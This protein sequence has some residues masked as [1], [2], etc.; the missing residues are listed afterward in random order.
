MEITFNLSHCFEGVSDSKTEAAVINSLLRCLVNINLAY[1]RGHAVPPLYRAGVVYGRT[2][3][4][5]PI[6]T[7][8]ERGYADCK[9][10][11]AWLCAEYLARGISARCVHRWVARDVQNVELDSKMREFSVR[12]FH[13]LVQT[14]RGYEDPSAKLGMN[15]D[16]DF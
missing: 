8:M 15:K 1:I 9:S 14:E 10:L 2:R 4:W 12:D 5:E 7:V 11:S 6:P 3:E 13:V 16:A